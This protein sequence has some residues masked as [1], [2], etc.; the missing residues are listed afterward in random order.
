MIHYTAAAKEDW[1]AAQDM[2]PMPSN[3]T[4]LL[5]L[6][7]QIC[8]SGM[9]QR[10][11]FMLNDMANWPRI[12]T[13][14][15]MMY[16]GGPN[17]AA[18]RAARQGPPPSKRARHG[19]NQGMPPPQQ[20]Q[21]HKNG[22]TMEERDIEVHEMS[23]PMVDQFDVLTPRDIAVDRYIRNHRFMEEVLEN[24][25]SMS[26]IIPHDLGFGLKGGIKGELGELT[27]GLLDLPINPEQTDIPERAIVKG[28]LAADKKAE[29]ERRVEQLITEA[30]SE[31]QQSKDN[32]A[33]ELERFKTGT[34]L[35]QLDTRLRRA[36]YAREGIWSLMKDSLDPDQQQLVSASGDPV[37]TP[38]DVVKDMEKLLHARVR[39][40]EA[41]RCI[42]RG[43]NVDLAPVPIQGPRPAE[44]PAH[45]D[46]EVD[47]QQSVRRESPQQQSEHDHQQN[48]NTTSESD[49]VMVDNN[50]TS[51][52]PTQSNP[53]HQ[54][55]PSQNGPDQ[56]QQQQQQPTTQPS[57]LT[58]D[59][60]D[61]DFTTE[62]EGLLDDSSYG[63]F[64]DAMH[65]MDAAA[66]A[67]L[68]ENLGMGMG[69]GMSMDL[70]L[71]HDALVGISGLGGSGGLQNGGSGSGAGVR[72]PGLGMAA[73][74]Q[75]QA[76]ESGEDLMRH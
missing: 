38:H 20:Q 6:H 26:D 51:P 68:E 3:Y 59:V 25:Y 75:Q 67:N 22:M 66:Q 9:I 43:R 60:P 27:D 64:G 65:G 55:P 57:T 21:Q 49:W 30:R 61:L 58:A 76:E 15:K 39:P 37:E 46:A 56:S 50:T 62:P 33:A 48:G 17:P 32:H 53:S 47:N 7:R 52:Q 12:S 74:E 19:T 72:I 35:L 41:R 45:Q 18:M 34:H 73:A 71:D 24:H 8:N 14:G 42:D 29:L 1:I 54:P 63:A 36:Q 11:D 23:A 70:G 44:M 10:K 2:P 5:N 31:I 13:P 69:M 16:P 40:F 28:H 4:A